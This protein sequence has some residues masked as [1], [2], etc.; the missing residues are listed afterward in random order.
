[1]KI[2]LNVWRLLPGAAIC[3]TL[4]VRLQLLGNRISSKKYSNVCRQPFDVKFHVCVVTG[5]CRID[6]QRHVPVFKQKARHK[7]RQP[8]ARRPTA[9]SRQRFALKLGRFGYRG[10]SHTPFSFSAAK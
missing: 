10:R 2:W 1:L 4:P 7:N 8:S 9:S 6:Y 5:M 3:C